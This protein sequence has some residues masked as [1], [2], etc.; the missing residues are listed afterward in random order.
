MGAIDGGG[1][2][3]GGEVTRGSG[4]E[5]KEKGADVAAGGG[6]VRNGAPSGD[7]GR[8]CTVGSMIGELGEMNEWLATIAGG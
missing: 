8:R 3:G 2:W 5:T 6:A 1:R 4:G 7:A